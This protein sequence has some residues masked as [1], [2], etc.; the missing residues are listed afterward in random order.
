MRCLPP[1]AELTPWGAT[2]QQAGTR[3]PAQKT[4]PL[5]GRTV[6]T[7]LCDFY[8]TSNLIEMTQ[9]TAIPSLNIEL[10]WHGV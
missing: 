5:F 3:S 10:W 2:H 7:S 4:R 1:G 9:L 8:G 6:N